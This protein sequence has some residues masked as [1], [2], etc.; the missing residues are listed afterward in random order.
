MLNVVT[1]TG[2]AS[3]NSSRRRATRK[4]AQPKKRQ[5]AVTTKVIAEPKPGNLAEPI[6]EA[7]KGLPKVALIELLLMVWRM[8]DKRGGL[9]ESDRALIPVFE[10][11]LVRLQAA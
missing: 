7:A 6:M 5:A 9:D 8:L 2:K 11:E 3:K 4:T 1:P 10:A